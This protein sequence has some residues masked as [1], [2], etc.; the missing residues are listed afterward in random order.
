MTKKM[1]QRSKN[2]ATVNDVPTGETTHTYVKSIISATK[3]SVTENK[4]AYV[5][6]GEK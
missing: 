3:T 4:L 1:E 2:T 5:V 6:E